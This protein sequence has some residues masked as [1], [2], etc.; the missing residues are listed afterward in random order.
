MMSAICNEVGRG[1]IWL[2]GETRCGGS[3][4]LSV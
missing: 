2:G 1:E 4:C 3:E